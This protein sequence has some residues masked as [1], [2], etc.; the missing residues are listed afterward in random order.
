MAVVVVLDEPATRMRQAIRGSSRAWRGSVVV[1]LGEPP[2]RGM[3]PFP[4]PFPAHS[5][6]GSYVI[7]MRSSKQQINLISGIPN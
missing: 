7:E 6:R 5:A 1:V 3:A 2:A 4:T